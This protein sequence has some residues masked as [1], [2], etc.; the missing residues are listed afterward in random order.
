[1]T[2]GT[3]IPKFT[4]SSK[5]NFGPRLA[6]TWSPAFSNGATVVRL[7]GGV[8][9]GPGQTEDQIQPEAN[10][11]VSRTFTSGKVYPTQPPQP[12]DGTSQP[13]PCNSSRKRGSARNTVYPLHRRLLR[14]VDFN[15]RKPGW[16]RS[17]PA[18]PALT[19]CTPLNENQ[20]RTD[21]DDARSSTSRHYRLANPNKQWRPRHVYIS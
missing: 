4:G 9:Y 20:I 5:A 3:I 19:P 17:K 21:N 7:G 8:F 14:S 2:A 15:S 13:D 12:R 6:L 18:D 11:R 1:M 16:N 10:D